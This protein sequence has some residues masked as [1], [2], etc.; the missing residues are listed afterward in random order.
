[1]LTNYQQMS[2][3]RKMETPSVLEVCVDLDG[4]GIDRYLYNYCSRIH[5]IHFDFAIVDNKNGILE[6][7]LKLF[8]YNIYRVPRISNGVCQ[9]YRALKTIMLSHHYDAIHV[10]LGV[11]SVLALVAAKRCGINVRI[12]HSHI[13]YVPERFIDKFLRKVL[14]ILTKFYATDLVSCGIDSAKWVW[15]EHSYNSGKVIIHNNAIDTRI[16]KYNVQDRQSVRDELKIGEDTLVVGHVGRLCDQKNQKRL[17]YI[18][19]K[20][21]ELQPNS[22]L[23]LVGNKEPDYDI[24]SLVDSLGLK[25]NIIYLGVRCDVSRLLNAMDIFVFPS[26][27]E[28]LPFTLIETQCNGL[29]AL[30]ASTVSHYVKVSDCVDF[31]SLDEPD[32]SWA[33]KAIA[34]SDNGHNTNSINEVIAGGYDLDT[35]VE[36]LKSFYLKKIND[37]SKKYR[38]L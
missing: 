19:R 33:V 23:L 22:M 38:L 17:L 16:Y 24:D 31:L 18:F 15:G 13:A 34:L 11:Y 27:Y 28:G 2:I 9:N 4:G 10:H 37:K 21:F 8:G 20:I 7:P 12:V 6:E 5:G 29:Y 30:C 36:N 25:N 32:E 3:D 26:K 14:T 1:M 35:E